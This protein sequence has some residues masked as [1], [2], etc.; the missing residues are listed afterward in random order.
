MRIGVDGISFAF[1]FTGVGRYL[2]SML[3][4][5]V[6]VVSA[7][8]V[9]IYSPKPIDL[10][11]PGSNYRIRTVPNLLSRRPTLW[12]QFI[13]PGLLK[14]DK[15][16]VFWAQPTNLPLRLK[17]PC[18][19][20]LTLHDLVPYIAP[21]SMQLRA[22][23]RMRL[24]LK[25]VANAADV[26]VCV[27]EFTARMAESFLRVN[28]KKIRVVKEAAAFGFKPLP[29]E[30]ARAIVRERFHLD[31]DYLIFVSTIEPRKDHPTLFKALRL[32]PEA[33]LLVL[34]GSRGWRSKGVFQEIGRLEKEGRVRYLGK[35]AD[36]DLRALYSAALL[37]VY[38]SRYEGFGLPVLEAMACGCPVLSSDSSSLPEVGG[39][40]AEYFRSGDHED[41]AKRLRGL[42]RN[43][44]RLKE[45]VRQGFDNVNKFSFRKA[46]EELVK[47]FRE[48]VYD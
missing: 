7:D 47:I 37:A 31:G 36:E 1:E 45:M 48:V 19:R 13:L 41:L 27:S 35:V 14:E 8:E 28:G 10:C 40:A 4:E 16:D 9:I 24:L 3:Q 32:V 29:K 20:V 22:L 43:E 42:L 39:E 2:L 33:P 46:A 44:E 21:E 18:R 5:L 6:Q 17:H 26:V 23:L 34:V 30:T 11:L 38:P 12:T 15:I 25:P